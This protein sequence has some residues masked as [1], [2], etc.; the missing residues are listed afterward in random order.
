MKLESK[1]RKNLLAVN[2]G[3]AS[4][5]I[6]AALKVGVGILGH[7]PAL[8]A[9]GI[10]STSDAVYLV[11]MRGFMLVAR[12]PPDR[13]HPYGHRQFESVA[14]VVVGAFVITTAVAIFWNAVDSVYELFSGES[15]FAGARSGALWV[16]V[17][18]V[19]TKVALLIFTRRIGR[20][21]G[22]IAVLALARD[23][24]NDIFSISAAAVG[25]FFGRLGMPWLDPA[26]AAVV[27]LVILKTGIEILRE[28]SA[29]LVNI[30]PEPSLYHEIRDLVQAVGGV[31][32]VEEIRIHRV[33]ISLLVNVVI[34]VDGTL[35]V[36]EG[37]RIANGVE[38]ILHEEIEYLRHVSVHFHPDRGP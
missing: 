11:I 4:N 1:D 24:R 27:S 18:T 22:S 3:L 32:R 30:L 12:K 9:D 38:E 23:H 17:F 14:A 15:H 8:L 16:A 13:E 10:S 7:S 34:G 21:T 31:R 37:D 28:S 6:L 5:G 20:Q 33:G 19:V 36:A 26:A 35:S 29:E 2:V 25:I